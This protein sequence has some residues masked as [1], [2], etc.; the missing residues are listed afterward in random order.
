MLTISKPLA[1][2]QAQTYH[3]TGFHDTI[4]VSCIELTW[5]VQPQAQ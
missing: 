3:P 5:K 2:G 4:A 1:A